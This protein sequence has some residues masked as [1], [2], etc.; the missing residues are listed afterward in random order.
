[1]ADYDKLFTAIRAKAPAPIWSAGVSLARDNK[2]V[3]ESEEADSVTFIVLAGA[4]GKSLEVQLFPKDLDW[5]CDC[6]SKS[7]VCEHTAAAII[8]LH[9]ADTRGEEIPTHRPEVARL[10]YRLYEEDGVLA[11]DRMR[12]QEGMRDV[13][14]F[15]LLNERVQPGQ[16]T[17]VQVDGDLDPA[18]AAP[19]LPAAATRRRRST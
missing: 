19:E 11:I 9:A 16:P 18:R 6:D 15:A 12:V 13:P 17:I 14:H 10:V 4:R 7:P 8:A 5:Q 3:K 1:M 2:I